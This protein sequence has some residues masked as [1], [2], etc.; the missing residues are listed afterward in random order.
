MDCDEKDVVAMTAF[1]FMN[2]LAQVVRVMDMKCS[3]ASCYE[4][5]GARKKTAWRIIFSSMTEEEYYEGHRKIG[6]GEWPSYDDPDSAGT[7]MEPVE[8]VRRVAVGFAPPELEH[9]FKKA[10]GE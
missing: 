6:Q 1:V 10:R 9:M 2:M 5:E 8:F 7:C 3:C 4:N